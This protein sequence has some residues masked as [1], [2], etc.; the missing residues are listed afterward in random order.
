ML[1]ECGCH[2]IQ[3][4]IIYVLNFIYDRQNSQTVFYFILHLDASNPKIKYH[5]K[6]KHTRIRN[7]VIVHNGGHFSSSFFTRSS[8]PFECFEGISF[9]SS[10]R[11]KTSSRTSTINRTLHFGT[12]HCNRRNFRSSKKVTIYTQL[13]YFTDIHFQQ[14]KWVFNEMNFEDFDIR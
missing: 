6:Q 2:I 14:Y 7:N 3:Q 5:L 8:W 1:N 9:S 13:D 10:N 11:R 12:H 4:Q